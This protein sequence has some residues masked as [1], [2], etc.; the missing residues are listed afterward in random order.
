MRGGEEFGKLFC[1]VVYRMYKKLD[2]L[3]SDFSQNP[4]M[5]LSV[6]VNEC[7]YSK[8]VYLKKCQFK[9]N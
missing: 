1:K 5:S 3:E 4:S 6:G 9:Y 2:P 7:Y 8:I